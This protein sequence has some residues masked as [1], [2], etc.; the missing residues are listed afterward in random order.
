MLGE[1]VR[2]PVALREDRILACGLHLA[3]HRLMMFLESRW[4]AYRDRLPVRST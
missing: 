3:V 2:V 4:T 1:R